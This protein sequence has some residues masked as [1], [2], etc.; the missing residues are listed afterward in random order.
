MQ[1]TARNHKKSGLTLV[2]LLLV[3]LT[4]AIVSLAVYSLLNNGIKIYKRLNKLVPEEGLDIFFD[5][6]SL[7]LKN[8]FNFS[9]I[10]FSG[11]Q[12]S[13]EIA[14]LVSSLK[15]NKKTVGKVIYSY[16]R[17]KKT[18]SR[19]LR[20]FSELS[21]GK[22]G[23]VTDSIKDVRYL[24]FYYYLYDNEK[25]AFSWKEVWDRENPPLAV[26]VELELDPE[27]GLQN[28]KFVK[29]VGISASNCLWR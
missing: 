11:G 10:N 18:I 9:G 26:R 22:E 20:D 14:T 1:Y 16:D 8:S 23:V 19:Q 6:F 29:T 13:F 5:K 7:D 2:E 3:V 12:D 28:K 17:A 24:K 21:S 27:N 15:L 25:N 4:M